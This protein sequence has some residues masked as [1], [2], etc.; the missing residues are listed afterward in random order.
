MKKYESKNLKPFYHN[1]H[2]NT[3]K[4]S[5]TDI[6]LFNESSDFD[7]SNL[8]LFK[9]IDLT[10]DLNPRTKSKKIRPSSHDKIFKYDS[11]CIECEKKELLISDLKLSLNSTKS[12]A[13]LAD[14][15]LKQYDKLLKLKDKRLKQEEHRLEHL[16]AEIDEQ[17]VFMSRTAEN[18][19]IEKSKLSLEFQKLAKV[20]NDQENERII[21]NEKKSQVEELL[22]V[23]LNHKSEYLSFSQ[24]QESYSNNFAEGFLLKREEEIQRMIEEINYI[25]ESSRNCETQCDFYGSFLNESRTSEKI[26]NRKIEIELKKLRELMLKERIE[27]KI[28]Y[29]RKMESLLQK[30]KII[31]AEKEK[32]VQAQKMLNNEIKTIERIKKKIDSRK[33]SPTVTKCSSIISMHKKTDSQEF[34]QQEPNFFTSDYESL[35]Q[36]NSIELDEQMKQCGLKIQDYEEKIRNC[37]QDQQKSLI[38]IQ[39][40]TEKVEELEKSNKE[41]VDKLADSQEEIIKLTELLEQEKK[42]LENLKNKD[43]NLNENMLKL[44]ICQLENFISVEGGKLQDQLENLTQEKEALN[45][46]INALNEEN[47]DLLNECDFLKSEKEKFRK[48]SESLHNHLNKIESS[49]SEN[50]SQS[51]DSQVMDLKTELEEKLSHL[52]TKEA[53]LQFFEERLN[54]DREKMSQSAEYIKS[55]TEEL[56]S[57]KKQMEKE[58]ENIKN[59]KIKFSNINKR[60]EEKTQIL[61]SKE[62]ELFNLKQKLEE[63]EK[64]IHSKTTV[65]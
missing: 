8:N 50:S 47:N 35:K 10:Q 4:P 19:Q 45:Q 57:H 5:I 9:T 30:E 43:Y 54:A 17:R 1:R 21:L 51:G 11:I 18:I 59:E 16:K 52:K 55:L 44:K 40:L 27:H 48:I 22:Q 39:N 15:H 33:L 63:R 24:I 41:L 23:Y 13:V 12:Q 58:L 32:V 62:K 25:N 46:K 56:T 28:E 38:K 61:A 65:L 53:E 37:E 6:D 26:K 3:P 7:H 42:E 60:L 20:R 29:E 36:S 64:L 31:E 34:P 49:D 2:L 14:Q